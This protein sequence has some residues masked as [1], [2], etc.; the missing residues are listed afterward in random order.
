MF[1]NVLDNVPYD[2]HIFD[3][4]YLGNGEC[5]LF[6]RVGSPGVLFEVDLVIVEVDVCINFSFFLGC[7]RI[8]F[9]DIFG[10][11]ELKVKFSI[12][13]KQY[14]YGKA[15]SFDVK[16]TNKVNVSLS[17]TCTDLTNHLN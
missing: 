7:D 16:S 17:G 6:D 11:K 2:F 13:E 9:R 12:A 3:S 14:F 1:K 5:I 8:I 15:L 10:K 4:C